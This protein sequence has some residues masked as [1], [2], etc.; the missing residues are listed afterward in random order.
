ML[1]IRLGQY[2]RDTITGIQGVVVARTEWIYGC[3]RIV[4]QPPGERDG[5]AIEMHS[6]DEPGCKVIKKPSVKTPKDRPAGPRP[7]A[8]RGR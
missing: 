7:E 4:I 5:K 3:V 8:T 2:A 1:R 6:C